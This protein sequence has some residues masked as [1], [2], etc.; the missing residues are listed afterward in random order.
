MLFVLL[1]VWLVVVGCWLLVVDGDVVGVAVE[2]WLLEVVFV[3]GGA[4]AL[5]CCCCC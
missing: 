1:L 3:V 4:V 2:C 5:W